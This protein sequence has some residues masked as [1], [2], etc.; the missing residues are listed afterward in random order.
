MLIASKEPWKVIE[1]IEKEFKLR[2][3]TDSPSYYLGMDI[4]SLPSGKIKL[5][6]ERYIKETLRKFQDEHGDI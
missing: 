1:E 3:K 2:N 6:A 5:S 4:K